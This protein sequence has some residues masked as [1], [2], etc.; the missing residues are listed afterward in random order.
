MAALNAVAPNDWR[1]FLNQRLTS[2][3]AT[4]PLGGIEQSGWHLVY[5]DKPN[6]A[7]QYQ[8]GRSKGADLNASLGFNVR[9]NG[10]IG[11]VVPESIAARAGL[12]PGARIVAVNGRAY[13]TARLRD[14]VKASSKSHDADDAHRAERRVLHDRIDRLPR[15]RALSASGAHDRKADWME[16]LIKPLAPPP[17]AGEEEVISRSVISGSGQVA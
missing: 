8:E 13:S 14:A 16:T 11:D 7:L 3:S 9:E 15:R 6:T 1:A 5:N 12:A 2:M 10:S 4:P 17:A